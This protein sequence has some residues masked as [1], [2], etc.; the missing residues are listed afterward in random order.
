MPHS[1]KESTAGVLFSIGSLD[2][3]TKR[4]LQA[5]VVIAVIIMLTVFWQHLDIDDLHRR[6]QSLSALP[7]IVAIVVLPL[8]GFPVSWLHLIAG[9]RFG[10]AHG[11]MVVAFTTMAQHM[12]GWL[13]VRVLPRRWFSRILP[14]RE[15]LRGAGHRDA[16]LLCGLLPGMP[17]SVQLYLL[18]IIGVPL[19][20]LI[21]LS[22]TLHTGRA[23][24]TILLGDHSEDLT[25]GRV[26]A[27]IIYYILLISVCW[28]ALRHLRRLITKSKNS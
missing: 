22:T 25:P 5:T 15:K 27:L 16:T 10:F 23:I 6:A 18:P 12:L 14:W 28:F 1:A 26:T 3:T 21:G 17:Y 11:L 4:L 20:L 9:V 24:V 7:V 13:L 2:I 8:I 19:Y